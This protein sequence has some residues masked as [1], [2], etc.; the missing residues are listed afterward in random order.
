MFQY[1]QVLVR[2][3]AGDSERD[4]ARTGLMG[5][6][7]AAK[8]RAIATERGWLEVDVELPDDA[9]IAAAMGTPRVACSSESAAKP[10]RELVAEWLEAG[11]QGK[12]IHAPRRLCRARCLPRPR[13]A[14]GSHCAQFDARGSCAMA[15]RQARAARDNV[16]ASNMN[17]ARP[18]I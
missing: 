11:V 9:A 2:L 15:A 16:S 10:G 5:R 14:D 18:P 6:E 7:K 3:R 17:F 8:V 12:A 1:R 13:R 4:I